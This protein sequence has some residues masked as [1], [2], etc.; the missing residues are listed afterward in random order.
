MALIKCSECGKEISDKAV[1]CPKCGNPIN[2]KKEKTTNKKVENNTNTFKTSNGINNFFIKN[3][4]LLIIISTVI[5]GIF[6]LYHIIHY[7]NIYQN[8]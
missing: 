5:V 1:S 6:G 3:K 4:I 7:I 2:E 8:N